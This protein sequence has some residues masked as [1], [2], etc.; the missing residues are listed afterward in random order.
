MVA[1]EWRFFVLFRTHCRSDSDITSLL[2]DAK[3]TTETPD[4]P[5]FTQMHLLLLSGPA[6][7]RGPG[8]PWHQQHTDTADLFASLGLFELFATG[9]KKQGMEIACAV[10]PLRCA[11]LCALPRCCVLPTP[12][13]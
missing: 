11:V 1:P 12:A 7:A 13:T 6:P 10:H 9:R 4:P 2:I 5:A 3:P 8:Y